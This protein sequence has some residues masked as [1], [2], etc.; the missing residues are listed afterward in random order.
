MMKVI[1]KLQFYFRKV[2]KTDDEKRENNDP[3]AIG[4]SFKTYRK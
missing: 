3:P 4:Q 2:S 1:F